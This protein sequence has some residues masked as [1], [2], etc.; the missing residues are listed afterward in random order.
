MK[1]QLQQS[2]QSFGPGAQ[3]TAIARPI[4]IVPRRSRTSGGP[5]RWSLAHRRRRS[6]LRSLISTIARQLSTTAILCS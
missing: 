5:H 4:G 2:L 1:I 3:L 6:S